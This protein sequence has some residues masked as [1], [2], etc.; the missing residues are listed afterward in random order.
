MTLKKGDRVI[1]T[2][3]RRGEEEHEVVSVGNRWVKTR[4]V[5][6]LHGP[7]TPF[8]AEP[9]PDGSHYGDYGSYLWPSRQAMADGEE[10]KRLHISIR[11]RL[12]YSRTPNLDQ[13]RRIAAILEGS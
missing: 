3:N 12:G 5:G 9:S 4:R 13:L 11:Q 2:H 10:H 6:S 8:D 7:G 1:V